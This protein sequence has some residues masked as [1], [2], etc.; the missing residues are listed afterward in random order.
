MIKM[1]KKIARWVPRSPDWGLRKRGLFGPP[2]RVGQIGRELYISHA[3][4]S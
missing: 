3:T 1:L 2:L 4:P